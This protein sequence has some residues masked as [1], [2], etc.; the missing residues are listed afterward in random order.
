MKPTLPNLQDD[1]QR[2]KRA[3]LAQGGLGCRSQTCRVR[4]STEWR[5]RDAA[6]QFG[7]HRGA[8]ICELKR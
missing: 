6:G 4:R 1:E 8:A 5:P 3:A 2:Q 7:G